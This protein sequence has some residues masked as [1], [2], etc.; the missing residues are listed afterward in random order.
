[1]LPRLS[2]KFFVCIAA[3]LLAVAVV[4]TWIKI[5]RMLSAP[6]LKKRVETA[7]SEFLQRPLTIE[8]LEWH[9]WPHWT[10]TGRNVR[11]WEDD[12]RKRTIVFSPTVEVHLALLSLYQ[13]AIRVGEIKFI[14]P[15]IVF[16]RNR[17]GAWSITKLVDDIQSAPSSPERR[18]GRLIFSRFV[19]ED[20][21]LTLRDDEQSSNLIPDLAIAGDSKLKSVKSEP[22]FSFEL[23]GHVR[24]SSETRKGDT[25]LSPTASL[26]AK[27][28]FVPS[29]TSTYDVTMKSSGTV[30]GIHCTVSP[31]AINVSFNSPRS[32]LIELIGWSHD[33]ARAIMPA[34]KPISAQTP[35][36]RHSDVAEKELPLTATIMAQ[37]AHYHSTV[38]NSVRANVRR[39]AG[40]YFIDPVE[41]QSFGGSITA[42][43]T[44]NPSA[45]TDSLKLIWTT[46]NVQALGLLQVVGSQTEVNGNVDLDGHIET[47]LGDFFLPS[48][49]GEIKLDM[50][51]GWLTHT[52]GL[53]KIFSKLNLT[54]LIADVRGAQS[55]PHVPFD[56]T[57]GSIKIVNGLIS[58]E[59]PFVLKN[60]TM[61]MAFTGSYDL[62]TTMIDGRVVVNILMVTDEIIGAIPG[63]RDILLGDEKS[64]IPIWVQV[65]GK[66]EDPQIRVLSTRSIA[67]PVWNT[68]SHILHLPQKLLDKIRGKQEKN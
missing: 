47:G 36:T 18:W 17:E 46:R 19:I 26:T 53:L 42:H 51:N 21:S 9:P 2:F 23:N 11:L 8:R 32:D 64:L 57:H 39:S 45:S 4:F 35:R 67:S 65:K 13:L 29:S 55:Q 28:L 20:G 30:A 27:G 12:A 48:M 25:S 56:E 44:Y 3:V 22:Q 63:V 62:T 37:D 34:Q 14:A 66:A 43:V 38:F 15:R 10:L 52:P 24:E 59:E 60:K 6:E 40:I 58:T 1:M 50:R 5:D 54:T 7:S 41:F 16:R 33:V 31:H 61:E 68:V 49:N